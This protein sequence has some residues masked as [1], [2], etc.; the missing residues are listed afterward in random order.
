MHAGQLS[1]PVARVRELVAAQ[2]PQWR[3]LPVRAVDSTGT[4][5][6]LLDVPRL[7][8]M[9]T[10]LREPPR[11]AGDV[12]THGDLMAGNV[13]VAGGRLTGILDVGGLG[14][15]DPTVDLVA[16]WHLLAPGP[17]Q[18]LRGDLGV[19]DLEWERGKA[20][21]FQPA[22]GL[23]WYYAESNPAMSRMGRR[24]LDRIRADERAG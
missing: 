20:W 14:P 3:R 24:T 10:A 16:G 23:V 8:R 5:N 21:A 17:R 4:V 7:R 11:T 1:V 13:L 9:W 12:I 15:A 19:G 2:F 18:A 22:L 6:A